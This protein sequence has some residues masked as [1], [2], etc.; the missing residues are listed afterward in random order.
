[1]IRKKS[2]TDI[3][4]NEPKINANRLLFEGSNLDKM[5]L[6]KTNSEGLKRAILISGSGDLDNVSNYI[7]EIQFEDNISFSNQTLL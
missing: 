6:L 7:K 1:M 4:N 5:K 3:S 2:K